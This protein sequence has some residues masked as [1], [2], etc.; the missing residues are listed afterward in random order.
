MQGFGKQTQS[1]FS[2]HGGFL[3][4]MADD[5]TRYEAIKK[6]LLAAIP[7]KRAIDKKLVGCV[8]IERD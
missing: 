8:H 1:E 6:E 4:S 3:V 2:A 5:K 7:K